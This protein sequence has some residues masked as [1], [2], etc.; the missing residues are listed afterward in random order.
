MALPW[1]ND[2]KKVGWVQ[3]A[4]GRLHPII[5]L[6]VDA[7]ARAN[8]EGG[9]TSGD[10]VGFTHQIARTVIFYTFHS[11]QITNIYLTMK[12]PIVI[13]YGH[14]WCQYKTSIRP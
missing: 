7:K 3:T 13:F 2:I 1:A 5:L 8:E 6:K 12:M 4:T 10:T 14:L 9:G 11:L